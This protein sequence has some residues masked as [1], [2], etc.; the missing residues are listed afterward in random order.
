MRFQTYSLSGDRILLKAGRS[1]EEG[2]AMMISLLMG[3]VLLAGTTGLMVRQLMARKLGA[4]E[5]YQQMA[6]S[7]SLSGL[8][9]IIS[10]LNQAD[11]ERDTGFL[12]SLNNSDG[13]WGW[14]TPNSSGFELVGSAPITTSSLSKPTEEK[15]SNR[16]E[17]RGMRV[18]GVEGDIELAYRLR[19]YNT[20]A[21]AGSGEALFTL[22]EW[23][24]AI[25]MYW[26]EHC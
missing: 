13:Q 4:S 24:N 20:T 14:S 8:N 21:T 9:R 7:A 12:R 2:M 3:V 15:L 16:H 17:R 26:H 5:S 1:K 19:S 11:R 22:K 6:E 25:T 18:D 10:D 23:S